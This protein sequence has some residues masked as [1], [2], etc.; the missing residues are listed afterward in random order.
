LREAGHDVVTAS[1]VDAIRKADY[2][3][4]E[5][6]IELD[7][8]V[9][10]LNC[11]DFIRLH[12]RKLSKKGSHP[13]ILLLYKHRSLYKA[14]SLDDIVKAIANLEATMIPLKNNFHV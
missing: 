12:E 13:G 11:S 3:V 1:D 8:L 2:A 10:T 5:K 6:A 4:F 14:M 7:R 9:L